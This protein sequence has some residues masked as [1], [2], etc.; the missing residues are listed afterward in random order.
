MRID[1]HIHSN[2]SGD[3]EFT[4]EELV[5]MAKGMGLKAI[6]IADHDTVGSVEEGLFWGEK[7]GVEVIPACEF[8]S[9]YN[10]VMLH[11]LGYYLN[12]H[13]LEM[14]ELNK[15]VEEDRQKV[16]D[17]QI[18]K[19]RAGGFFI[20]KDKV[21]ENCNY[22]IPYPGTYTNVIFANLQNKDNPIIQEY[23]KKPDYL[24]QFIFDY[25]IEGKPYY[26]SQFVPEAVDVIRII[27]SG[28]GIPVLAHPGAGLK[29]EE[30][31]II[32][33]LISCGVAGLEVYTSH[34]SQ[35]QEEYYFNYC[36]RK[37]LI[38]TCGSDFHGKFKPKVTMGDIRNN[39]YDI[40]E[41]LKIKRG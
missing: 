10:G 25:L 40:V 32:D 14:Q 19:L 20:D 17:R 22:T 6:A 26:I 1:L 29:E 15:K 37:G 5:K 12:L 35:K 31:P 27:K 2:A 16:F 41:K 9:Y 4:A 8:T 21:M 33:E 11:M 34:H 36:Q 28:G 30:T 23:L 7:L 38:F 13:N 3:G 18:E 24:M 39:T